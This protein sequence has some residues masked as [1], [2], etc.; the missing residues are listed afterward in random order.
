VLVELFFFIT[1]SSDDNATEL[2][3]GKN[4]RGSGGGGKR[5]TRSEWRR[6][7]EVR[8]DGSIK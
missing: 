5:G 4:R 7:Q 3:S 2:P 1:L 6:V 8:D